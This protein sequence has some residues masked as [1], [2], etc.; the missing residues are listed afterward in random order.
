MQGR[1]IVDIGDHQ[2]VEVK[3]PKKISL[4]GDFRAAVAHLPGVVTILDP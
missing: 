1:L 3:L 2:E 4:T